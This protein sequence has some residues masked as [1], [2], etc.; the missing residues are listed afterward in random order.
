[1][2]EMIIHRGYRFRLA[3]TPAQSEA[4]ERFAGVCRLIY[5]LAL[6]QRRDWWRQYKATEGR[7]ISVASQCREVTALRAEYGWIAEV[8]TDATTYALRDLGTAFSNFFSGRAAY[9]RPRKKG[10]RDGFR[11]KGRET[12][13][14]PLNAKWA[15]VRVPKV[16]WV[17]MRLT[18]PMRGV[19]RNLQVT[20]SGGH[21]FAAFSCEWEQDDA[22]AIGPGVGIDRGVARTLTLST[23]EHI[24]APDTARLLALRKRAQRTL[25]RRVRGS[26][27]YAAQRRKVAAISSK[28]A[29]VR[30]DWCHRAST[31]IANRFGAV[32]IEALKIKNMTASATGTVEQPGRGVA[33]KRGLNRSILEQCWG[34]FATLLDYKLAERGGH[35]I[36]VP[37]HHTSQTCASCGVVDARSREN[38]AV[39]RCVHCG[40]ED[41]ADVNAA[42]EILRRST[43]WLG[44]KAPTIGPLNRQPAENHHA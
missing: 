24:Q 34:K 1:M 20:Q 38:Q 31:D 13:I 29:R 27:R 41:N 5:N 15:A 19:I 6:E 12:S 3:P 11:I 2:G 44:A 28:M 42:K 22:T 7:S 39:F 32:A 8:P 25:A 17:K 10:C 35:L 23:G 14:R 21:W 18:R 36:S 16:G 26:N 40:H 37:A 9:P 4:F 30:T 43:A 33:Q